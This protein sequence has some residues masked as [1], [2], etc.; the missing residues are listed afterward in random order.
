MDASVSVI[1]PVGGGEGILRDLQGDGGI[2]GAEVGGFQEVDAASH[3]S[4]SCCGDVIEGVIGEGGRLGLICIEPVQRTQ[5]DGTEGFG[6][7]CLEFKDC[8]A[9]D[10]GVI[11]IDIGIFGGGGD[12]GDS[13]VLDVFEQG[14][15][16]FFV[17]ILDFVQRR[18]PPEPKR[19]DVDL[20][21]SWTSAMEAV[22][23]LRRW[24]VMPELAAMMPAAVV[25]PVPGG[26]K[27]IILGIWPRSSIRRMEPFLPKR[28]GW[29]TISSRVVGRRASAVGRS[30]M[31][32]TPFGG[33]FL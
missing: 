23:A 2:G 28:W 13:A 15:L 17:E 9:G 27:K 31:G 6:G 14:L 33:D 32:G 16:L 5:E 26:P 18:I 12:E 11:D 30:C 3:I 8:R 20:V 29:P 7:D 22:V 19:E 4:G 25:L 10:D 24:R 21:I 1:V